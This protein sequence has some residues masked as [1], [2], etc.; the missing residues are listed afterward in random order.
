MITGEIFPG[1]YISAFYFHLYIQ[2][3]HN[4]ISFFLFLMNVSVTLIFSVTRYRPSPEKP[5][6]R[7]NCASHLH[8]SPAQYDLNEIMGSNESC[9]HSSFESHPLFHLSSHHQQ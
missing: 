8:S 9:Y 4:T 3:N 6:I 7:L 2:K 1:F 5:A